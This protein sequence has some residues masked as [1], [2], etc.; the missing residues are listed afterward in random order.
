MA[1]DGGYLILVNTGLMQLVYRLMIILSS[2]TVIRPLGW[3]IGKIYIP[4]IPSPVK[5]DVDLNFSEVSK[6]LA[7]LIRRYM[8]FQDL[9]EFPLDSKPGMKRYLVGLLTDSV[10]RFVVAHEY[11]H[12]LSGH[13]QTNARKCVNMQGVKVSLI[14]KTWDQEFEADRAACFLLMRPFLK[15]IERGAKRK[16]IEKHMNWWLTGPLVF[17]EIADMLE[18]ITNNSG[19]SHPP[20]SA[21]SERMKSLITSEFPYV[22]LPYVFSD[23]LKD[24][25]RKALE[26]GQ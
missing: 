10:E 9:G 5:E 13:L 26:H 21:R 11:G 3:R 4:R 25:F 7:T 22:Q 2:Q 20:A 15:A 8:A 17:F 23:A 19:G 1:P 12:I 18:R 6:I 24:F 16:L 14:P